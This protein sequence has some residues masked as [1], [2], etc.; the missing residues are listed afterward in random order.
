[1][2][3]DDRGE[4]VGRRAGQLHLNFAQAAAAA[5]MAGSHAALHAPECAA[6]EPADGNTYLTDE[7]GSLLT[8]PE[9]N[10]IVEG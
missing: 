8:D 3:G 6:D 7:D 10:L 2:E 1:M 5:T 9:G 4:L